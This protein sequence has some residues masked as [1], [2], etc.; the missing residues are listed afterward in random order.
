MGA[1]AAAAIIR[2]EREIVETF[3]AAG[4][5]T[6]AAAKAPGMLGVHQGLAFR[7]LREHAVLREVEGGRLYLDEPSWQALGAI[8]HRFAFIMITLVLVVGAVV[9]LVAGR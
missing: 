8:R 1:V 2:K 4:A 7:R 9:F 3:R 5:L 6:P